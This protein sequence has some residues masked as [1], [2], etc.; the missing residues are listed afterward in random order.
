MFY[1]HEGANTAV[2]TF[3]RGELFLAYL[4]F[5]FSSHIAQV[6]SGY[7]VVCFFDTRQRAVK[8]ER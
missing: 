5:Q 4:R 7:S 1:S 3:N 8:D 6:R 2:I